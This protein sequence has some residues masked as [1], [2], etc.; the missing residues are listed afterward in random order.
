RP[1]RHFVGEYDLRRPEGAGAHAS[2][3]H[4]KSGTGVIDG[5][6]LTL[7]TGERGDRQTASH[8][9]IVHNK[10]F[11]AEVA[12]ALLDGIE[13]ADNLSALDPLA[14]LPIVGQEA[15]DDISELRM[16]GDSSGDLARDIACSKEQNALACEHPVQ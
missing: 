2:A 12:N 16:F 3:D 6:A 14:R 13:V 10:G 7:R 4:L 8:F 1:L 15:H 11:G 5:E 9:P